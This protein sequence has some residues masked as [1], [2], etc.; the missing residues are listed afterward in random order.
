MNA[1]PDNERMRRDAW[2]TSKLRIRWLRVYSLW[3][4]VPFAA[5]VLSHLWLVT[6]ELGNR[7]AWTSTLEAVNGRDGIKTTT[8]VLVTLPL[9]VQAVAGAI[10]LTRDLRAD[11]RRWKQCARA[12]GAPIVA[13]AFLLLHMWELPLARWRGRVETQ[14]YY[15]MLTA[16]LSSTAYGVPWTALLYVLGTAAVVV[17]VSVGLWVLA[18]S[19][20]VLSMRYGR[21]ISAA[22][23]AAYAAGASV[24]ALN[25]IMYFATGSKLID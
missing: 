7:R 11:T 6:R 12:L 25:V 20:G 13:G 21:W 24:L 19:W 2:R 17:H 18:A 10:L 14:D 15:D 5:F 4:V 23:V 16:G 3:G 1:L 22:F 9:V 8:V